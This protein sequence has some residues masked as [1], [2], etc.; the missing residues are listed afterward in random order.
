MLLCTAIRAQVPSLEVSV[1]G[2]RPG[3]GIVRMAICDQPEQ[4]PDN[5]VLFFN[6][7]KNEMQDSSVSVIVNDLKEG[8]YAI[9]LLDDA[10]GNE[11]MDKGLF[12]IPK[13]GYGFSNDVKPGMKCP[14]FE[15]CTFI[16]RQGHN[17][18]KIRMQYFKQ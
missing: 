15:L 5:P 7:R 9:T 14:P 1:T 6:F 11:K 10:N 2:I 18:L 3:P 17:S 4:F 13:E 16:V 12:G 8:N